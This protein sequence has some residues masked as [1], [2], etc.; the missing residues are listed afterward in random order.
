MSNVIVLSKAM[1][2]LLH[3]EDF[4]SIC[5][6][7]CLSCNESSNKK[8]SN[9]LLQSK[10]F[11]HKLCHVIYSYVISL[12][13]KYNDLSQYD[14]IS[15]LVLVLSAKDP[16]FIEMLN[17]RKIEIGLLISEAQSLIIV[18]KFVD[19]LENIFFTFSPATLNGEDEYQIS[20]TAGSIKESIVSI[21]HKKE[22]PCTPE[23]ISICAK[24]F[25]N[26]WMDII[27]KA[28]NL[29]KDDQKELYAF[30]LQ[31][32]DDIYKYS[33]QL[34]QK[35][36]LHIST[37]LKKDLK[38]LDDNN[39]MN[40]VTNS[41][42]A[43]CNILCI[44]E[45]SGDDYCLLSDFY[46][47]LLKLVYNDNADKKIFIPIKEFVFIN[48]MLSQISR[49]YS[50]TVPDWCNK[51]NVTIQASKNIVSVDR[52]EVLQLVNDINVCKN[53]SSR[54]ILQK[55]FSSENKDPNILAWGGIK[56]L[57]SFEGKTKVSSTIPNANVSLHELSVLHNIYQS[58]SNKKIEKV[59]ICWSKETMC[60]AIKHHEISANVSMISQ[61]I[62]ENMDLIVLNHCDV[63]RNTWNANILRIPGMLDF[64][65]EGETSM[66]YKDNIDDVNHE[67]D[68]PCNKESIVYRMMLKN[69][70]SQRVCIS[71]CVAEYKREILSLIGKQN[72]NIKTVQAKKLL[73]FVYR[74]LIVYIGEGNKNL[75]QPMYR[76]ILYD[77]VFQEHSDICYILSLG[78][79]EIHK[80]PINLIKVLL[81]YVKNYHYTVDTVLQTQ[82]VYKCI[83][84]S[85][86]HYYERLIL[87]DISARKVIDSQMIIVLSRL[88]REDSKFNIE[89]NGDRELQMLDTIL[90]KYNC[91]LGMINSY[92]SM[93][94]IIL[95]SLQHIQDNLSYT[96]ANIENILFPVTQQGLCKV[97]E[98]FS[99][100][101]LLISSWGDYYNMDSENSVNSVLALK[102]CDVVR[103]NISGNW[104]TFSRDLIKQYMIFYHIE[105]SKEILDLHIENKEFMDSLYR[106]ILNILDQCSILHFMSNGM[107][108]SDEINGS[109][110]SQEI[111]EKYLRI[112][113]LP[114]IKDHD[115][116]NDLSAYKHVVTC[117]M[118][119][120][121]KTYKNCTHYSSNVQKNTINVFCNNSAFKIIHYVHY[122]IS[123]IREDVI[124][125]TENV[126]I[127][128][129]AYI[130]SAMLHD[131][132]IMIMVRYDRTDHKQDNEVLKLCDDLFQ[133]IYD[134]DDIAVLGRFLFDIGIHS[135]SDSTQHRDI[136]LQAL[137]KASQVSF[138]KE[139]MHYQTFTE[140]NHTQNVIPDIA[141]RAIS[142][143]RTSI[144][145]ADIKDNTGDEVLDTEEEI[146]KT[147]DYND[148]EDD[149]D[150]LYCAMVKVRAQVCEWS[151]VHD[152]SK[153]AFVLSND[154]T[155]EL[156]YEIECSILK[157][158]QHNIRHDQANIYFFP[159]LIEVMNHVIETF[160][161]S[162][163]YKQ[164]YEMIS[165]RVV[166][167]DLEYFH[168]IEAQYNSM[169]SS[170]YRDGVQ[171]YNKLH[172]ECCVALNIPE[173]RLSCRPEYIDACEDNGSDYIPVIRW[174]VDKSV[175]QYIK[176]L[177]ECKKPLQEER[178][179]ICELRV[180][181]LDYLIH[182]IKIF[183][184]YYD[185]LL[186]NKC[187]ELNKTRNNG[188]ETGKILNDLMKKSIST[189]AKQLAQSRIQIKDIN[190][191]NYRKYFAVYH[192]L[193]QE[194]NDMCDAAGI[195]S[196]ERGKKFKFFIKYCILFFATE[197]E[198]NISEYRM[199]YLL[200]IMP[201][202]AKYHTTYDDLCSAY[203]LIDQGYARFDVLRNIGHAKEH[204]ILDTI[205][206]DRGTI[207]DTGE[208]LYKIIHLILKMYDITAVDESELQREWKSFAERKVKDF[209]TDDAI[210]NILEN[211]SVLQREFVDVIFFKRSR[212]S[213]EYECFIEI[214]DALY[215][216]QGHLTLYS[217]LSNISYN[218]NN[219]VDSI[220]HGILLQ[221]I[222]DFAIKR[223]RYDLSGDKMQKYKDIYRHFLQKRLSNIDVRQI[224]IV[225]YLKSLHSKMSISLSSFEEANVICK[226]LNASL[227]LS[228]LIVI[229]KYELSK[230]Q[231][232]LT[233]STSGINLRLKEKI[234]NFLHSLQK[235]HFSIEVSCDKSNSVVKFKGD[236]DADIDVLP[237]N[238]DVSSYYHSNKPEGYCLKYCDIH[239]YMQN[240]VAISEASPE[241]SDCTMASKNNIPMIYSSNKEELIEFCMHC[242]AGNQF[243]TLIIS[244]PITHYDAEVFGKI[245]I[246]IIVLYNT[247]YH[248]IQFGCI[249]D[250]LFNELEHS[251]CNPHVISCLKD[252]MIKIKTLS[253]MQDFCIAYSNLKYCHAE[254]RM[255]SNTDSDQYVSQ[256]KTEQ[257]EASLQ[258][259]FVAYVIEQVQEKF[260]TKYMKNLEH[261]DD[262]KICSRFMH[263]I[264]HIMLEYINEQG[265]AHHMKDIL[266]QWGKLVLR[267]IQNSFDDIYEKTDIV[268]NIRQCIQ[269]DDA[270]QDHNLMII[271]LKRAFFVAGCNMQGDANNISCIASLAMQR[272]QDIE[273]ITEKGNNII[274]FVNSHS[275][276]EKSISC[277]D[278]FVKNDKVIIPYAEMWN[279]Y[280]L[281]CKLCCYQELTVPC[282]INHN[283]SEDIKITT[284]S[285]DANIFSTAIIHN[286]RK[287]QCMMEHFLKL[288]PIKKSYV[289]N[290]MHT[291][292]S[293]NVCAN[294]SHD[295]QLVAVSKLFA[296]EMLN[297]NDEC[298]ILGLL[299]NRHGNDS[300][301]KD[302]QK[303]S[304]SL[305]IIHKKIEEY[306]ETCQDI[307]ELNAY[308][309]HLFRYMFGA[310]KEIADVLLS[311][312]NH[313]MWQENC[314]ASRTIS[315]LQVVHKE[316]Q[317][318]TSMQCISNIDA[319]CDAM[320]Y[321]NMSI[322]NEGNTGDIELLHLIPCHVEG[323]K[324]IKHAASVMKNTQTD[325]LQSLMIDYLAK[326]FNQHSITCLVQIDKALQS[327]VSSENNLMNIFG[328]Q[329]M[330]ARLVISEGESAERYNEVINSLDTS[331]RDIVSTHSKESISSMPK[332]IRSLSKETRNK[333]L[334]DMI[335]PFSR[336][337]TKQS[338]I[339]SVIMIPIDNN[340]NDH[341]SA[342]IAVSV[343]LKMLDVPTR[344][345]NIEI[346]LSVPC[347]S[348]FVAVSGSGENKFVCCA[349]NKLQAVV[350]NM[351]YSF[352][353]NTRDGDMLDSKENNQKMSCVETYCNFSH[354]DITRVIQQTKNVNEGK[355]E[356]Y[357]QGVLS[358]EHKDTICS[359]GI[360]KKNGVTGDN[361]TVN[362]QN[363]KTQ[364][365]VVLSYD[366]NISRIREDITVSTHDDA[367]INHS[368]PFG[369][370]KVLNNGNINT[371]MKDQKDLSTA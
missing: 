124:I 228:R 83:R 163:Q 48:K 328:S 97:Q 185:N 201:Y 294:K 340:N 56:V 330:H 206:S 312:I 212:S 115:E 131:L 37:T 344:H 33:L 161:N 18:D 210:C 12:D 247:L 299:I 45:I 94:R 310:T 164:L 332:A 26:Y 113:V 353:Q 126:S 2:L 142:T 193:L 190:L 93:K 222:K 52:D 151:K 286:I 357:L 5:L 223:S 54:N 273:K 298:K 347:N 234:K 30:Y 216:E 300:I 103:K 69:D 36:D 248:Y 137:T 272:K 32:M 354:K 46:E 343:D 90:C 128:M 314:V 6:D 249:E 143:F 259:G 341:A 365:K 68:I 74:N 363:K 287:V 230:L 172:K 246:E 285:S 140:D 9:N 145:S 170:L 42:S 194:Y 282:E 55:K 63:I 95:S 358:T 167:Q 7:I 241:F 236:V 251:N 320:I 304:S 211:D 106:R 277:N 260:I 305:E 49:I 159:L 183:A 141:M 62:S 295:L 268:S 133:A 179:I 355:L 342:W 160:V 144:S 218:D 136:L 112:Y 75:N 31:E 196:N 157:L 311:C 122:M 51:D 244:L 280:P 288:S 281:F 322:V 17:S 152:N 309:S 208:E 114:N 325:N 19:C 130:M 303:L 76:N 39:E 91:D 292:L 195:A 233:N 370:P 27:Q 57:S 224:F 351:K 203:T 334:H 235:P 284:M 329:N 58:N 79:K 14:T 323:T 84:S 189:V 80:T 362:H 4:V 348:K 371:S 1:R 67:D 279:S 176:N 182:G 50:I 352:K 147:D 65:S 64:L 92:L 60:A 99:V 269:G 89:S 275:Q 276:E 361:L 173:Y 125:D 255:L 138:S 34:S 369:A 308:I 335:M 197:N 73:S 267:Y 150:F 367:S 98:E 307:A 313:E 345:C 346:S 364:D 110:I 20:F 61:G 40:N 301:R 72:I 47:Y 149:K 119:L 338:V 356:K 100:F 293:S 368:F 226:D 291:L 169:L 105:F 146:L 158:L 178:S 78:G 245:S 240:V 238:I 316:I 321:C 180:K 192:L 13:D 366:D 217:L 327:L 21:M 227:R 148:E 289:Y 242:I 271:L 214:C 82:D 35:K 207:E 38:H 220:I 175:R 349:V 205:M 134:C 166:Y 25:S 156:F 28:K 154:D 107:Q 253:D 15:A 127:D 177:E 360:T 188:E 11:T 232:L 117:M 250:R 102:N 198:E 209:A 59:T 16:R 243:E 111:I 121:S 302:I 213:K 87:A 215:T 139:M 264:E 326:V 237:T 81:N 290:R 339:Q 174:I 202:T 135:F 70:R 319:I 162:S 270:V 239:A 153:I 187:L 315:S 96:E 258:D 266:M 23:A 171:D 186:E 257:D 108:I 263:C 254:M 88:R 296:I 337:S 350:N 278:L 283:N 86:L 219:S 265:I 256:Q 252:Q 318:L 155:K 261:L 22:I 123:I 204:K 359:E 3:E 120:V 104:E 24:V 77:K 336:N 225:Q 129:I 262:D 101:A 165:Y 191:Q 53:I 66:H 85:V 8:Y 229:Y 29:T 199:A 184:K 44:N 10:Y 274:W 168:A 118:T 71:A 297:I 116:V 200:H 324:S 132:K 109:C 333:L 317:K 231:L 181:M 221:F 331:L 41:V 43:S 306:L